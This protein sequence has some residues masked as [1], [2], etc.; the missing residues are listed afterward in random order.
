MQNHNTTHRTWLTTPLILEMY[1][2]MNE[3]TSYNTSQIKN[4]IIK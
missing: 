4:Y 1:D 3:A 2:I